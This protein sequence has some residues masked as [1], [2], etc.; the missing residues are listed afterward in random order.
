MVGTSLGTMAVAGTGVY[1]GQEE[2]EKMMVGAG[3][4]VVLMETE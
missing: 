2:E 4:E 3:S 1:G